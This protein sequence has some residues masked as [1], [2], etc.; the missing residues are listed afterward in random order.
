MRQAEELTQRTMLLQ[1]PEDP[2][3]TNLIQDDA[4][5]QLALFLSKTL[6]NAIMMYRQGGPGPI[7]PPNSKPGPIG[8]PR[9]K[10]GMRGGRGAEF[11]EFYADSSLAGGRGGAGRGGG[12]YG[13]SEPL[14]QYK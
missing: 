14:L 4:E 7:G 10:G 11:N 9:S 3:V 1:S 6:T 13:L 2:E 8:P 5:A 12:L